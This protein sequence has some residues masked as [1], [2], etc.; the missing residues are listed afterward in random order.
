MPKRRKRTSIDIPAPGRLREMADKLW[1]LAVRNDWAYKCAVCG[2]GKCQAHHLVPRQH[3]AT[4]YT[5]R[6]GIALCA[7]CH[8]F[9]DDISPHQNAAGWLT[10]LTEN[11]P[12][13]AAWYLENQRPRFDGT[14]NAQYYID[15][16]LRLQQYV[17]PDDFERICGVRFSQY[18][19]TLKG[20][21]E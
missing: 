16:L 14:I 21:S 12:K 5:L 8:Q 9:D 20:E 11:H 4:R 19:E 2:R 13:L 3:H 15:Q 6:N 7:R 18:L 1:S 10:W 17:E